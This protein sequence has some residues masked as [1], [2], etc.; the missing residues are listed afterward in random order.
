MTVK[1]LSALA[2]CS[3]L[4]LS[5]EDLELLIRFVGNQQS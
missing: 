1:G 3:L 2:R 4:T 5:H